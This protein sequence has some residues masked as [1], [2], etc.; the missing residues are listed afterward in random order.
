M[1]S[2]PA[3][4]STSKT[5]HPDATGSVEQ[6]I[7]I[8]DIPD[9]IVK[10]VKSGNVAAL[11]TTNCDTELLYIVN[12]QVHYDLHGNPIEIVGNMSDIQGEFTMA[13]AGLTTM[14]SFVTFHKGDNHKSPHVCGEVVEKKYVDQTALKGQQGCDALQAAVLP[15]WIAIYHGQPL[16]SGE[17]RH[18]S[19]KEEF[20][21]MG[22]GYKVW[23]D[24]V[25][26]AH[27]HQEAFL[28]LYDCIKAEDD[29]LA[30][31]RMY[32]N[33]KIGTSV[34]VSY[35]G[36]VGTH[37]LAS[38][39]KYQEIAK[40]IKSFFSPTMAAS[41]MAASP[42]VPGP[43][44]FAMSPG[45][46]GV[47]NLRFMSVADQEKERDAKRGKAKDTL[48]LITGKVDFTACTITD[49]KYPIFSKS[50][51]N[52]YALPK[53]SAAGELRDLLTTGL[54]NAKAQDTM[55]VWSEGIS[56]DVVQ[57]SMCVHLLNGNFEV[58]VAASINNESSSL[59]LDSFLA[60][61]H[62]SRAV[63]EAKAF[64]LRATNE[65]HADVEIARRQQP[66]TAI[67][68]VGTM[69]N[70]GDFTRL[71]VNI[72]AIVATL[73]D[74]IEMKAQGMSET[75]LG[76]AA[77]EVVKFTRAVDFTSWMTLTGGSN[78]KVHWV[79]Y[80][81]LESFWVH[82]CSFATDY[83]NVNVADTAR[84][85]TELDLAKLQKAVT[86][87]HLMK[88]YFV[89][90]F[91][92]NA[93]STMVPRLC[94]D[95]LVQDRVMSQPGAQP[96][97]TLAR[98]SYEKP[99]YEDNRYEAPV[100]KRRGLRPTAPPGPP[101]PSPSVDNTKK[102]MFFL[103][104]PDTGVKEIFPHSLGLSKTPCVDFMCQGKACARPGRDCSYFHYFQPDKVPAEDIEKIGDHFLT[105][106]CGWF[107]AASFKKE[108]LKPKHHKLLGNAQGPRG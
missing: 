9:H 16:V 15:T 87:I 104:K 68:R 79:L 39:A 58:H 107:N 96:R 1:S 71:N 49:V 62:T 36:T 51:S 95:E 41:P 98:P 47:A 61:D 27:Q 2:T 17:I 99:V 45:P 14:G 108:A 93:P 53:A 80:S 72:K 65:S 97:P 94:P 83:G 40:K 57:K 56:I 52:V 73:V 82:L 21:K 60:Q 35:N 20:A 32:V 101:G 100:K 7:V 64:E 77:T 33:A 34:S 31:R 63:K 105:T 11:A 13:K 85:E 59:G 30:I 103:A 19:V 29:D 4:F 22:L 50:M 23:A 44:G 3:L 75:I 76:Q 67:K 74:L 86:S 92:T 91:A 42:M 43:G 78:G 106:K 24:E 48:L 66:K 81:Y 102:G 5:K 89:N 37:V 69:V 18:A 84:P 12:P 54:T 25:S 90:L 70:V 6:V 46:G 8:Q 88:K 38:T 55:S 10:V 28:A 26:F